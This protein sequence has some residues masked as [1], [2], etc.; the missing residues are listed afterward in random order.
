M[1]AVLS[2]TIVLAMLYLYLFSQYRQ[3]F[4]AIWAASWSVYTLR[5]ILELLILWGYQAPF[6][7][8]VSLLATIFSGMLLLWGTCVLLGRAISK[9]WVGGSLLC[10]LWSVAATTLDIAVVTITLPVFAFLGL[11]Y[12][13]T[14]LLL[15]RMPEMKGTGSII[16]GAAF[17]LWGIHKLN[18]P[19]LQPLAWF[20]PWG[21]LIASILT[22]VV[23][24]GLILVYF[25][26]MKKSLEISEG[27]FRLLAENARD[28]IYRYRLQPLLHHEYVSPSV[29]DTTGYTPE[30]FYA[31]PLLAYKITFKEDRPLL[32][33]I[34]HKP[35]PPGEPLI[36]RMRHKK[37]SMLWIEQHNVPIYDQAGQY[38]AMEGIARDITERKNS[39]ES[40]SWE[41]G[42]NASIVDILQALILSASIDEISSI[43]LEH[44]KKITGSKYGYAGYIDED[45][46]CL[47][48]ATLTRDIWDACN[49]AGKN[50]VF[51]KFN[52]LWGWVLSTKSSVLTNQ[53]AGDS[54]SSGIP[55]GHITIVRFLSAP[56]LIGDTLLGQ[57]ALANS[58]RDYTQEDLELVERLASFYAL[59]IHRRRADKELQEA[60]EAA[61]R[62]NTEL[63][64]INLHLEE[65]TVWV[66]EMAAQAMLANKFKSEFL[67]NMSHEIRTPLN[68]ILGMTELLSDSQLDEQQQKLAGIVRDSSYWLLNVINDILDFSKIEA[69][70][71]TIDEICFSIPSL[72]RDIANLL[73]VK[74]REKSLFLAT[75]TDPDIPPVLYGDPGRIRQILLNLVS[76]AIKFTDQGG[77]LL[78][79]TSESC[80]D[81]A[82]TVRFEIEDTGIGLTGE[83]VDRVFQPFVQA[84]GSITRKFGGTGLGLT[85]SRRLVELMG[86]AIGVQSESGKGS[87]FWF[88]LPL[89]VAEDTENSGAP[90]VATP[91]L[92]A[93]K[94]GVAGD[95]ALILLAEDNPTSR[96]LTLLQLAKLGYKADVAGNGREAVEAVAKGA[97]PYALVLMDCQMPQMDG[98]E[99]T[100]MIR[101]ME[102]ES[103]RRTPIIAI[104]AHAMKGDREQ[105]LV[106]GMDDYISKPVLLEQLRSV[107]GRW[108]TGGAGTGTE[109]GYGEVHAQEWE[110]SKEGDINWQALDRI[111]G[112]QEDNEPSLVDMLIDIYLEDT[113][114]RLEALLEAVSRKDPVAL[115]FAAHSIKS[116]SVNIGAV[117][118]AALAGE[119]ENIGRAGTV[120]GAEDKLSGILTA[121]AGARAALENM[122]RKGD[123]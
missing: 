25:E 23:A 58:H 67:A 98:L 66:K 91:S 39:E 109:T 17:I 99:A 87:T 10:A 53:P 36:L 56:A 5:F 16:T 65:T 26:N 52:G 106:A 49:I 33:A 55:E 45:S 24:I 108:L 90:V 114:G 47:V 113:P 71:M 34:R 79:A 76:N 59:A 29:T 41:A 115:S 54:R 37:G 40:L 117:K 112:I 35:L 120:N 11:V 12:I 82:C 63:R 88:T 13:W 92:E 95:G 94:A 30:E 14:G 6:L 81:E 9:Y 74:A 103:G 121:F 60:R 61:E 93:E 84:D 97:P 110:V 42:V 70:K 123:S 69:G 2:A 57:V 118:V 62:A 1:I 116:G 83:D 119:L 44:A 7:L 22:I 28:L 21:Y 104:T 38:I 105:C 64:D 100:R 20:A 43:V 46:G 32:E 101:K 73:E 102:L 48:S 75:S 96:E 3:K 86:G 80:N 122:R 72:F 78:S 51:E 68:S 31:D 18:Y 89:V 8:P 111:A 4:L 107:I 50:E 15:L 77:V 19:F 85:I 27:R